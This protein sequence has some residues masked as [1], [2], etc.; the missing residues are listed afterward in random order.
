MGIFFIVSLTAL[1][2]PGLVIVDVS[3]SHSDTPQSV[4]LLWTSDLPVAETS[5]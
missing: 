4:G 5:T 2:D 1:V 3:W